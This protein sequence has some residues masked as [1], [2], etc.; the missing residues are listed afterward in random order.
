MRKRSGH[1]KV[2]LVK[3]IE[4]QHPEVVKL[5]FCRLVFGLRPS[6]A[7]LGAVINHHLSK[8]EGSKAETVKCLRD[9][10]YVDDLVSGA[11]DNEKAS[12]LYHESKQIMKEGGFNLRKWHSNSQ[13]FMKSVDS[14]DGNAH[15][16]SVSEDDQ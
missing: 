5:R 8:Y 1:V 4:S 16:S 15:K 10:L 6:P 11:N 3:K 13:Q 7:I 12:K 2:S 9:S 14:T